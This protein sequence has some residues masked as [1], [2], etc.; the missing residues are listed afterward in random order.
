MAS[1]E[2]VAPTRSPLFPAGQSAVM[3]VGVGV[4][5]CG[6]SRRMWDACGDGGVSRG[7]EDQPKQTKSPTAVA[8]RPDLP[9]HG[10][11][12]RHSPPPQ[13]AIGAPRHQRR[14]AP[15]TPTTPIHVDR[16]KGQGVVAPRGALDAV[17][18]AVN[19]RGG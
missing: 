18:H 8:P 12:R 14:D 9:R 7:E 2:A 5:M 1:G 16:D 3:A 17:A 6:L 11:R 19:A 10:I 4:Y 13:H 15:T